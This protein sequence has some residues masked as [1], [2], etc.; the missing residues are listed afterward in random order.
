MKALAIGASAA[1]SLAGAPAVHAQEMISIG[2]AANFGNALHD[3][4]PRF[5]IAYNISS[6]QYQFQFDV[7]STG[8]LKTCIQTSSSDPNYA[9]NCP[10]AT[11]ICCWRRTPPRRPVWPPHM[12]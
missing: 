8:F 5:A 11:T 6:S 4:L 12:E 1:F 10:S 7:E 3:L 2:V 9:T